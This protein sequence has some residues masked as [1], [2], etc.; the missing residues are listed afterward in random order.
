LSLNPA[1]GVITGTFSSQQTTTFGVQ[2]TVNG[3]PM[4]SSPTITANVAAAAGTPAVKNWT[5]MVYIAGDNDLAEFAI[6]DLNELKAASTNPNIN[7][8]IQIEK[9]S[10]FANTG[11]VG[12]P[13]TSTYRGLIN[14]VNTNLTDIGNKDMG[15]PTTL[16]SFITWSK[17]NYPAQNYSLVLWSHGGGWKTNKSARG[18]LQDIS[19]NSFMSLTNIRTGITNGMGAGNK[20]AVL[21]FDACQM[22]QYEV[23][24]ELRGLASYLVA[25]EENVPGPGMPYTQVV[26]L[27]SSAPATTPQAFATG[28]AN[29]FRTSYAPISSEKTTMS[30]TDLAQ[31]DAVHAK[32]L[33]FSSQ[34]KAALNNQAAVLN[35]GRLN[36]L[37]FGG[38]SATAKSIDL[39]RY[40]DY[41]AVNATGNA[42]LQASA[43]ALKNTL[44]AAV[45]TNTTTGSRMANA[46]G[47]AV[48]FPK[49]GLQ[50]DSL[51]YSSSTL[52]STA[53]AGK[54][55]W[56][57][58]LNALYAGSSYTT[59]AVGDFAY[60]MTW[61]NPPGIKVDIDLAMN[62]PRGN[63][64]TASNGSTSP[65]GFLSGDSYY[66]GQNFESYTAA[67]KVESGAYD[68]FANLFACY[69]ANNNAVSGAACSTQ[70]TLC[71]K[72]SGAAN[73]VC[74]APV[75]LDRGHQNLDDAFY[76]ADPQG[77][78]W[79]TVTNNATR[80]YYDWYYFGRV[81]KSLSAPKGKIKQQITR[82]KHK[83]G[84][85]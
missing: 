48:Y 17:S 24:Y 51:L 43:T 9:G 14:G 80:P 65:N 79:A 27:L 6:E 34:A 61:T 78:L 53:V 10:T 13:G 73:F 57:E 69:D 7:I 4:A 33:D 49:A 22:G 25:S 76:A 3:Y 83:L 1:T 63:W 46:K 59:T 36:A 77:A 12:N 15:S 19:S 66:S 74:R 29:A 21:T 75:T 50:Y 32:V 2:L 64:A 38:D 41:V 82:T 44:N 56:N 37:T 42:A 45:I 47:M 11:F 20:L 81:S 58:F 16:S 84:A 70:V 72:T 23:A 26:N 18:A 85:L 68:L 54:T 40:A 39:W 30:V 8:V 71:E 31:M 52:S 62:E 67:N 35:G 60:Y 5:M 55:T 28:M